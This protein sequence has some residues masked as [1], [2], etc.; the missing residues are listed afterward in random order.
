MTVTQADF[1]IVAI[2][3]GIRRLTASASESALSTVDIDTEIN[4]FGN[5]N[6]PNAIKTDQ[7]R[8]VYTFY[9]A[10]YID[11]YP[12]DV[13]Y[14]QGVR[15]PVYIDGIYGNLYKDRQSFYSVWPRTSTLRKQGVT[16][17]TGNITGINQPTNPTQIITDTT[18]LTTGDQI[19]ISNVL[20][21]TDLN[22]NTYTI[23]V[24]SPTL[25]TL[26]GIDNTAFGAYIS[27]G[28]W[29]TTVVTFHI[30]GPFLSKEVTIGGKDVAGNV[31][32]IADDG[33]GNLQLQVPNR[34]VTIPPYTDVYTNINAPVPALIG[35]PI[36]GMHNR[37]TLNPGLNRTNTTTK[38]Y[39]LAIGS[40]NYVTG[41]F[42]I[43]FPVAPDPACELTVFVK[44]YQT[45]KPFDLMFWNNEFTIRPVP[46]LVHKVEVEVYLTPVQ[47][48]SITD[49]PIMNQWS[50]YLQYGVAREILRKRGDFDGVA[51]LEEGF[52][53][54]EALVLERQATE[55]IG[56]PN[57]TMFNSPQ[58]C[59]YGN[60]YGGNGGGW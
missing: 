14:N 16:T 21:M 30:P 39:T 44:Q 32:Q 49:V 5:S 54:Q 59:G 3:K 37:N 33:V 57:S 23:T 53:Y 2:R 34:V 50:Q 31:I 28:T 56:T 47:F 6:F 26:N 38:P 46:K 58:N 55:E 4:I 41:L 8:S 9:T 12:L 35:K 52:L 10:P 7:M 27:G 17:D 11:R 51:A 22:G 29:T 42:H 15:A 45:G 20:G 19:T 24:V 25:L 36:P 40:V 1:S 48:L 13:N 18:E 60:F 43:N